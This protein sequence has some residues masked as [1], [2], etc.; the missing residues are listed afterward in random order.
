M[1]KP[2][3]NAQAAIDAAY[4]RK[5]I[6][7]YQK[8]YAKGIAR[9]IKSMKKHVKEET[10]M[11]YFKHFVVETSQDYLCQ[12]IQEA[13]EAKDHKMLNAIENLIHRGKSRN[14]I[15]AVWD[16]MTGLRGADDETDEATR[17]EINDLCNHRIRAVTGLIPL[18]PGNP[19]KRNK[20]FHENLLTPKEI[21]KRDKLLKGAPYHFKAHYQKACRGVKALYDWDLE[22]EKPVK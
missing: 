19:D 13:N 1:N 7:A 17:D 18:H 14:N 4:E 12:L 2:S 5:R 3:N 6:T 9:H 22:N 8:D 21:Q 15:K 11:K 16:I 10:E 20:S